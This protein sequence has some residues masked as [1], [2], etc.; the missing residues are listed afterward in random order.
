[1]TSTGGGGGRDGKR[2]E[3]SG[4]KIPV[5]T[6]LALALERSPTTTPQATE[7]VREEGVWEGGRGERSGGE[8]Q[9]RKGREQ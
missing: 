5:V 2:G 7:Q 4:G 9:H 3:W 1:M 8:I 6:A